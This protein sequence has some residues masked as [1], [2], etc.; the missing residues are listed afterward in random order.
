MM[1]TNSAHN[2]TEGY[3]FDLAG[4]C[5][6][7]ECHFPHCQCSH[8]PRRLEP[9]SVPQ[10]VDFIRGM[11]QLLATDNRAQVIID[12][13]NLPLLEAIEQSLLKT[14]AL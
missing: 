5:R 7:N 4:G 6:P 11:R 14:H 13:D 12:V 10:Q 8:A 2:F 1:N 9:C 3:E